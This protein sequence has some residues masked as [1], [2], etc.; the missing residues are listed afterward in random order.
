M[1]DRELIWSLKACA[2]DSL[3]PSVF[4][5]EACLIRL[6]SPRSNH[7]VSWLGASKGSWSRKCC[8]IE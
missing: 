5:S 6:K 2:S 3:K 7:G 1:S 8:L 4:F